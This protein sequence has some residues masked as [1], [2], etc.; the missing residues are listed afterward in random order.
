MVKIEVGDGVVELHDM[1]QGD[2]PFTLIDSKEVYKNPWIHVREDSVV[3][4]GGKEGIFGVVEMQPGV[5]VVALTPER[6]IVLVKEFKYALKHHT[7]ECISGG[8]DEDEDIL[9]AAKRELREEAG[10]EAYTWIDLGKVDPF[11]GIIA[12]CNYIYLAEDTVLA[13]EQQTDEGEVIEVITMSFEEALQKVE[14]GEITHSAS[15]VGIL[16]TKMYLE[17]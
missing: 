10:G 1:K 9:R 14:N 2:N 7:L 11:T 15:V 17:G 13:S 16:K 4:P 5:T 3:R 6:D 8:V 12:S